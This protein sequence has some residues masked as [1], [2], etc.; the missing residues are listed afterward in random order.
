V[1]K[2]DNSYARLPDTFFQRIN[3]TPVDDPQLIKVNRF[4]GLKLGLEPGF[5]TS[6]EGTEL[7]S[8]N[9]IAEG[10]DPLAMV[11]GGQ[12]FGGWVP[13]LGD[14]RVV[15][16]GEVMDADGHRKDIQLKGS[17]RT[18]YS[19]NGDGRAWLGP[20]LRE[21][22]VSEAMAELN[23]PTTRAL[24][25][26]TTGEDVFR[27][28]IVPGAILTRVA[29]SHVRVG[30]FQYFAAR[31]DID[32]LKT[33]AD[34]VIDRHFPDLKEATN[35]YL[36]LLEQMISKQ[37]SLIAKWMGVGFIH[38]VMNTDN[39]L[40]CG[41]TLDY[42]PCA[43]MDAYDPKTVFSS[44]DRMGRYSY[45]NQPKIAQWNCAAFASS[46]LPL[47]HL[48]KAKAIEIAR[49][50][51]NDFED[52]YHAAW[53]LELGGKLGLE[54]VQDGD[55]VLGQELLDC[56]AK[57]KIDF[58]LAFRRLCDVDNE[59]SSGDGPLM[60]VFNDADELHA[61]LVKWRVRLAQESRREEKRKAAMRA[62]NPAFIPRNHQVEKMIEKAVKGNFK[63]FE[64]LVKVL[65]QPFEEQEHYGIY[66][67]PPK[68]KIQ[69]YQTYCGT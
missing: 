44:I 27:E 13:Q 60:A 23:I 28:D 32:G 53:G 68:H 33:L 51:V 6:S 1:F 57:Y 17:G 7:F 59:A 67:H 48:E 45:E 40:I 35:P 56:M 55:D 16:L 3:P 52:Q 38:G 4:L 2:F 15:L 10:S 50:T 61:W 22:V 5:L 14:G 49:D 25:V 41:E 36:G 43:F 8:G 9:T 12:Q 64:K 11:Y 54:N 47:L 62:I 66:Q 31:D 21:Y 58:T 39:V 37:A 69:C 46:L 42:G 34:Y 26:V 63:P 20:V 30:T 24:A 65:E 29:S 18:K 19:R